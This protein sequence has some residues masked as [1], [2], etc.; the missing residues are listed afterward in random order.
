MT[1]KELLLESTESFL[2]SLISKVANL[3]ITDNDSSTPFQELGI[4]SFRI[5]QVIKKLE[6]EFGTLPKTL[7]FENFNISDL[8][9]YFVNKHEHT[10]A[11]I[12]SME[13]PVPAAP[14]QPATEP[15]IKSG[16]VVQPIAG[17]S[18]TKAQKTPILI[19]EKEAYNHPELGELIKR[20]FDRYKSEG[21]AS[22][23]TRNIA[24]NLF[25]GSDKRGYFNYSRS[26]NIVLVYAYTGPKEYF[27]VIAG[28]IY[29]HCI[30][31]NFELN[32]FSADSIESIGNAPFSAT[33]FG[34]LQRI[35]DIQNFTLEGGKMRRLRY[36]VA[37]FEDAG[38]CKTIEY[39]NGTDKETDKNIAKIIDE[40]CA[41]RTMVNPLIHIVKE[42][43]LAGRLSSEHR[44]FLT[45][46]NEVLQNVILISSLSSEENGYLMDL[47]FYPQNMPLGGLEYG[48]VKIIETLAAEGYNMLSMGGTYGCKLEPSP[49]ADP[50]LDKALDHLREQN[51]FNVQ[52]TFNLKINFVLR[53]ALFF[54]AGQKETATPTMLPTLSCPLPIL[55][56]KLQ[57]RNTTQLFLNCKWLLRHMKKTPIAGMYTKHQKN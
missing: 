46:L 50:E 21:S 32:I 44:L 52:E 6:E 1:D 54:C 51:I 3:A 13:A 4:D 39:S 53:T 23:G 34:A 43:I 7:L 22:R 55:R 20:L 40:W 11:R 16:P 45:Y 17:K 30:N 14:V 37:K 26:K 27:P 5:L 2:K 57:M 48:I 24:P 28:E 42:E 10:L 56:Y 8:S 25:I 36:Q 41:P 38:N 49:N 31:N 19:L 35:L 18:L 29:V 12:F 9:H 47:E 33:P 15:L